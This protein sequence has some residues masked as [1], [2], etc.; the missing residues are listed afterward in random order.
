M[1]KVS[2]ELPH[3]RHEARALNPRRNAVVS[4]ERDQLCRAEPKAS[5]NAD[6]SYHLDT[7]EINRVMNQNSEA[8]K[9]ESKGIYRSLEHIG[10]TKLAI[11]NGESYTIIRDHMEK[12]A[13]LK[14]ADP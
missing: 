13:K 2:R 6:L 1:I 8:K 3:G 10:R 5:L 11:D 9:E 4:E 14:P 12:L 7:A